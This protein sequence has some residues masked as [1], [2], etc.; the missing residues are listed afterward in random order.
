M[1]DKIYVLAG[2]SGT[3][4]DT[5]ADILKEKYNFNFIT[6]HTTRPMREGETEG[7]PYWFITN[8]KFHEMNSNNEFI[9]YRSYNTKVNGKE[10]VW[11]YAAA[12]NEVK[13]GLKYVVVLDMLGLTEFKEVFGDRV[14]GIFIETPDEIREQRAKQRGSF[15]KIEWDRRL[16]DDRQN[17]PIEKINKEC[18]HIITNIDLDY[19]VSKILKIK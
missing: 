11:Y 18:D 6:S 15:D 4:K 13:D 9:E 10:D 1:S 8:E 12:K 3:G 17:F 7:K 14:I 19:A 2:F 16:A 5:I